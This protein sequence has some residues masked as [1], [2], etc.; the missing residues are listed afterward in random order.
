MVKKTAVK[1]PGKSVK[2]V[3][4]TI[5]KGLG[6]AL[7]DGRIVREA[8]TIEALAKTVAVLEARQAN[9]NLRRV[10]NAARIASLEKELAVRT[11]L[12]QKVEKLINEVQ[13]VPRTR[14]RRFFDCAMWSGSFVARYA[15]QQFLRQKL[16]EYGIN[17]ATSRAVSA[18]IHLATS[19]VRKPVYLPHATGAGGGFEFPSM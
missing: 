4:K 16:S 2:N 11:E 3:N 8:M 1:K 6:C 18:I 15:A 13:K 10:S 7:E 14:R 19:Y 9:S 12:V 17:V 5:S